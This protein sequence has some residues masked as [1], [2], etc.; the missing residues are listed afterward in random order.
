[1][2]SEPRMGEPRVNCIFKAHLLTAGL[3]DSQAF[4]FLYVKTRCMPGCYKAMSQGRDAGF[5]VSQHEVLMLWLYL[6]LW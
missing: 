1:M 6:M 5:E 4:I 3:T 2:S